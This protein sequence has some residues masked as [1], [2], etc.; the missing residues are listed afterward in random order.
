MFRLFISVTGGLSLSASRGCGLGVRKAFGCLLMGIGWK[1]MV[2]WG[3]LRVFL[4]GAVTIPL[5][6]KSP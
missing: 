3:V 2:S 5:W 6:S 4:L 1:W